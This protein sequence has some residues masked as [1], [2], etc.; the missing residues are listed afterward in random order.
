MVQKAQAWAGPRRP[1]ASQRTQK[2]DCEVFVL[3]LKVTKSDRYISWYTLRNLLLFAIHAT[4][5]FSSLQFFLGQFHHPPSS[6]PRVISSIPHCYRS[7]FA[8]GTTIEDGI[9]QPIHPKLK[10][11]QIIWT[12]YP[13]FHEFLGLQNVV[14]NLQ[15]CVGITSHDSHGT[16]NPIRS[17][18]QLPVAEYHWGLPL[19]HFKTYRCKLLGL[20]D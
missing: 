16:K 3:P 2:A 8:W 4:L 1:V 13:N 5:P 19:C 12:N 15:G 14:S 6:G 7:S 20:G 18:A 10:K 9:D 11:V 17:M